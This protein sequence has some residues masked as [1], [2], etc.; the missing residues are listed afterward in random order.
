MEILNHEDIEK[1]D[2]Y[3]LKN[4]IDKNQDNYSWCPTAD[5]DYAFIIDP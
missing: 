5:C 2:I 3:T 4:C 1:Y